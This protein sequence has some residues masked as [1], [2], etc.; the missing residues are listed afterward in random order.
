MELS[1]GGNP[2]FHQWKMQFNPDI[3][4]QAIEVVFSC[5]YKKAEHPPLLFNNIPVARKDETKHLGIILDSKLNFRKHISEELV[6]AK[7]GL[8]LLKFL[9]KYLTREKLDLTYKMHVRPYLEYGDVLFHNCSQDLMSMIES[10][11]YQAGLLVSGCWQGTNRVTLYKELGWESLDDRRLLHRL[12]LYFK[13]KTN[14]APIYLNQYVLFSSPVGT[15]RYKRFFFPSCFNEW[16]SM[17]TALKNYTDSNNFKS[18]YLKNIRPV[19]K[20]TYKILDRYGL[21]LLSCLRVDFSDLR[22]HRFNHNFNCTDP[23]CKCGFEEESTDHY[24][25]RC[26][27]FS[28]SRAA[29]LGRVSD[30]VNP[31]ILNLP[32]D[33]LS[34]VLLSG[35][36]AYNEITNKLIVEATIRFIKESKRF[37]ILEA[38]SE[39]SNST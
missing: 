26:P 4:K 15:D 9:S 2:F 28:L 6:K 18:V 30:A 34:Q 37:K 27:R 38:F 14:V 35:S 31:E 10:I 5:K 16:E 32:H 39:I 20:S 33:H 25:L 17:D 24:L 13:I 8:S 3:T 19:K 29:L 21:K 1:R 36:R 22:V 7:K 12:T 11:Q 23:T